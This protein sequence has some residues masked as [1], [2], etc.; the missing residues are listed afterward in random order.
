MQA[1]S[2]QS[3]EKLQVLQVFGLPFWFVF[4]VGWESGGRGL[5]FGL[6]FILF[7]KE[8]SKVMYINLRGY[9]QFQDR[10]VSGEHWQMRRLFWHS[11]LIPRVHENFLTYAPTELSG[12]INFIK[13]DFF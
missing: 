11:I 6:L 12:L 3:F 5:F 7:F 2:F 9:L 10:Y 4:L 1:V 13:K 8:N